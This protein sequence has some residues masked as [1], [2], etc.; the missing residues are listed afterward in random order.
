MANELMSHLF[1][2]FYQK[3]LDK[4]ILKFGE[5]GGDTEDMIDGHTGTSC[6]RCGME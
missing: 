3:D 4:N 1:F 2:F 6:I 5:K